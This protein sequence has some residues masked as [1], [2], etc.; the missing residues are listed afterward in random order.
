MT[1][2]L[3]EEL[4][5]RIE[6]TGDPRTLFGTDPAGQLAAY[7]RLARATHPDLHQ[8]A[9]ELAQQAF[10]GLSALWTRLGRSPER[11]VEV[12]VRRRTYR[13]GPVVRTDDVAVTRAATWLQ[14]DGTAGAAH[15][16][17]PRSPDDND[18]MAAEAAALRT[19]AASELPLQAFV[20]ALL[21]TFRHR[22]AATGAERQATVLRPPATGTWR[23]LVSVAADFP[24]GLDPRDV[25][26]MWR[27][28]LLALG[29]AHRSGLVH[30]APVPVNVLV[31]TEQ[32][33]LVL[34]GW[35]SSVRL[36]A[37]LRAVPSACRDWYPAEV[38]AR[39]PAA[40]S[41]DVLLVTRTM[42][43]LLGERAPDALRAFAR[44]CTSPSARAR[45]TDAWQLLEELTELVERLYGP[46][47]FRPFPVPTSASA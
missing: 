5:R 30:G 39:T 25:V 11:G 24:G 23:D 19:L 33:G 2:L 27:R 45:P 43:G 32:H 42:L 10:A 35:T 15:V 8:D 21:E 40:P 36:G 17:L 47:R 41:T 44:G 26:W 29:F 1:E 18:L 3:L 7:R 4:A 20:P 12:V 13:L 22:D 9:V 34:T 16:R 31:E 38:T 46:R 14:A 37:P 28:A 6:M